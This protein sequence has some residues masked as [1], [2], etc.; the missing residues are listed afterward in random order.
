M[1]SENKYKD[2]SPLNTIIRLRKIMEEL[3]ILTEE[4]WLHQVEGFYSLNV[5]IFGTGL[6]SNGKGVNEQYALASGYAELLE[7]IQNFR[8]NGMTL[9]ASP[10]AVKYR[11]FT[12]SPD[13]IHAS[14]AKAVETDEQWVHIFT[15]DS[16][17]SE[18]KIDWLKKWAY[19]EYSD[20]DDMILIPYLNVNKGSVCYLPEVIIR[21][22]CGTNGMCAGNTAEEALVQGISELI[23][24]YVNNK[25]LS[26]EITPPDIPREY[27]EKYPHLIDMINAI[28]Q[29]GRSKIIVKDC[30]CGGKLPVVGVLFIDADLH[31][32]HVKMG[33]HPVFEIALERCLT[34]LLQGNSIY[35]KSWTCRF[36]YRNDRIYH[37]GNLENIFISGKGYYPS[38]FFS[39]QS[40]YPF[41]EPA[42][43][44]YRSNREMLAYLMNIFK[45]RNLDIYIKDVSFLGFP[46]F[47]IYIPSFSE[48]LKSTPS[49]IE[50]TAKTY[51]KLGS[52]ARK[53][54][55]ASD[56]ELGDLIE[57]LYTSNYNSRTSIKQF[58]A[59]SLKENTP[60]DFFM[61]DLI[62][63]YAHYRRG[64]F[65]EA[66]KVLD[67]FL[68]DFADEKQAFKSYY[69]CI[70][71]YTGFRSDNINDEE[72]IKMGLR[73][74][75]PQ[76]LIEQVI[77][78]MS[79]FDNIYSGFP[80]LECYQCESCSVKTYCYYPE[81]MKLHMRL[82]DRYA[83]NPIDQKRNVFL[84]DVFKNN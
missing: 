55:N 48:I 11:G 23:E 41:T 43:H 77:N 61:R 27:L 36:S 81:V 58:M 44:K 24:R 56:A 37:E 53:P 12:F 40:S 75:Y 45:E 66:Y 39:D 68:K 25:F 42:G 73:L 83:E 3:C 4:R 80:S 49:G 32:Y 7:R 57:Y 26:E 5:R 35:D 28:E 29:K 52:I 74:F 71:D 16:L 13:E 69:K 15:P 38:T 67:R 59:V 47:Y 34:E 9:D 64:E 84:T 82:K 17:S 14:I 8:L 62:I 72:S 63:F 76:S 21:T 22:Y 31:K 33:A 20:D 79:N 6:F 65:R 60:W 10:Q 51:L 1:Y 30:S 18:E 78:D 19:D 50:N 54:Q 70:R 2:C 46:S